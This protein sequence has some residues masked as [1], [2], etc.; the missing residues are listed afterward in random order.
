MEEMNAKEIARKV[1]EGSINGES[2]TCISDTIAVK[3]IALY[4]VKEAYRQSPDA[5]RLVA[6]MWAGHIN[7]A[8]LNSISPHLD[9]HSTAHSFWNAVC[10][11]IGQSQGHLTSRLR[12][13]CQN[14]LKKKLSGNAPKWHISPFAFGLVVPMIDHMAFNSRSDEEPEKDMYEEML[15]RKSQ[16]FSNMYIEKYLHERI[17]LAVKSFIPTGQQYSD[18][19]SNLDIIDTVK[20]LL[21]IANLISDLFT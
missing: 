14:K 13:N 11:E 3:L 8:L 18:W 9:K 16:T 21:K 10:N 4:G 2:L 17:D 6:D 20:I 1:L 19:F 7:S 12:E 15:I 5:A